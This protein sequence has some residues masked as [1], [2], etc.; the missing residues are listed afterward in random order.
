MSA[1]MHAFWIILHVS[2]KTTQALSND[3]QSTL[4]QSLITEIQPFSQGHY[5]LFWNN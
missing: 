3:L 2:Y 4:I 1:A 5:L